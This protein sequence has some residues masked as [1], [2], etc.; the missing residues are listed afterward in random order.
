MCFSPGVGFTNSKIS[1]AFYFLC[2]NCK[3]VVEDACTRFCYSQFLCK[4]THPCM[5]S[6]IV[7]LLPC[8]SDIAVYLMQYLIQYFSRAFVELFLKRHIAYCSCWH[9]STPVPAVH[10]NLWHRFY[11]P[12]KTDTESAFSW[13]VTQ[14]SLILAQWWTPPCLQFAF[15]STW[16]MSHCLSLV[17]SHPAAEMERLKKTVSLVSGNLH[18][19]L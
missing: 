10:R 12:S 4:H 3:H 16:S 6:I 8:Y 17:W 5:L 1:F 9:H 14:L 19:I 2:T 15:A 18:L 11:S 13:T 7:S